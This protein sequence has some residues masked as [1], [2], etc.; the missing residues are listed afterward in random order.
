ML[1]YRLPSALAL[2]AIFAL[3]IWG[4][5]HP[6]FEY[7]FPLLAL[8]LALASAYEMCGILKA[9]KPNKIFILLATALLIA[10]SYE[11]LRH[12]TSTRLLALFSFLLLALTVSC[13]L[14]PV[15]QNKVEGALSSISA[16]FL[17]LIYVPGLLFFLL[18]SA[19][20]GFR[21]PAID[22]R[23]FLIW[24]IAIVKGTDIGAYTVG[25][26]FAK[27]PLGNHKFVPE[28]SP[29]KSIEG[30]IGGTVLALLVGIAGALWLPSVSPAALR[31]GGRLLPNPELGRIL[32][33]TVISLIFALLGILG[34]L[35]ES[36]FK[37]D[38]GVKDSGTLI[39]GMGGFLDVMDS[40]LLTA[41]VMYAVALIMSKL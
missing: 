26:A 5:Y 37:R 8:F 28:I 24:F 41:P 16:N 20:F 29:K 22:G 25:T 17:T 38:S 33:A 14:L 31:L 19:L 40:L 7:L 36:V 13:F 3:S 39:P 4:L 18:A 11:S 27:S 9:Q 23:F 1:K 12:P 6:W 34:D 15:V 21:E 30:V 35:V 32:G 10:V 2:I